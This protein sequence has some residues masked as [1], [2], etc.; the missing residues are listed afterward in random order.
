VQMEAAVMVGVEKTV[1]QAL[2][3][4]DVGAGGAR[5]VLQVA[6][7]MATCLIC[8]R[9]MPRGGKNTSVCD[10]DLAS[11]PTISAW[12]QVHF[13]RGRLG[14]PAQAAKPTCIATTA[15]PIQAAS[16]PSHRLHT[17]LLD[18][19]GEGHRAAPGLR[20]RAHACDSENSAGRRGGAG[21]GQADA[22]GAGAGGSWGRLSG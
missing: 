12:K 2:P 18:L 7:V 10:V 5:K 22:A 17:N 13:L 20:C 1:A 21:G 16:T 4:K 8:K 19:G 6:V 9:T 11:V 3:K 15:P 14:K